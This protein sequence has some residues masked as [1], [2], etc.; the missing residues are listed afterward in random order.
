[1]MRIAYVCVDG[2]IPIFGDKGG[3]VHVRSMARAFRAMGHDVHVLCAEAGDGI[4]DFPVEAIGPS[5]PPAVDR[6]A[7]ERRLLAIA[8]RIEARSVALHADRPFDLIYE[9]YGLWSAAGVRAAQ[10]LGITVA[11]EVNAPLVPDQAALRAFVLRAEAMAIEA[12]VS[13]RPMRWLSCHV[14]WWIMWSAKG[15]RRRGFM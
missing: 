13:A 6:E 15:P 8:G 1:M 9:H 4:A 2:G 10:R 14:N 11:V 5:F 12:E 3:S 7:K